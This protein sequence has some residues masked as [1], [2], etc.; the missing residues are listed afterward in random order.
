MTVVCVAKH[1]LIVTSLAEDSHTTEFRQ[2][3]VY[4]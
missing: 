3:I 4:L 1:D 2:S